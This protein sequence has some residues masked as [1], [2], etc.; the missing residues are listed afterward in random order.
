MKRIHTDVST[1][2]IMPPNVWLM[3]GA[4]AGVASRAPEVRIREAPEGA[5]TRREAGRS[6]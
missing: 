3:T 2:T 6:L 1:R 5:R 4:H